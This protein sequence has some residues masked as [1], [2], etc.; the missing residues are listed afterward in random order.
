MTKFSNNNFSIAAKIKHEKGKKKKT[1]E[2]VKWRASRGTHKKY[3]AFF[4]GEFHRTCDDR[5]TRSE[6]HKINNKK[7]K[8]IIRNGTRHKLYIDLEHQRCREVQGQRKIKWLL[9]MLPSGEGGRKEDESSGRG[10]VC[11]KNKGFQT[12]KCSSDSMRYKS[13]KFGL[14][15]SHSSHSS[16]HLKF[17]Q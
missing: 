4:T 7:Y 16:H 5:V 1:K 11:W 8:Y 6:K 15:T 9:L 3:S 17:M 13:S 2:Q 10:G 14:S 12:R